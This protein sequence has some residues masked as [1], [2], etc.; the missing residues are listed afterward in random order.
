[1]SEIR[2][3]LISLVV[4]SPQY[5]P[6]A[7][8]RIFFHSSISFASTAFWRILIKAKYL[9]LLALHKQSKMIYLGNM[10]FENNLTLYSLQTFYLQSLKSSVNTVRWIANNL[11]VDILETFYSQSLKSRVSSVV[12]IEKY[13]FAICFELFCAVFYSQTYAVLI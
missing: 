4:T 12:W 7:F 8:T 10:K 6:P 3:D 9:V 1:M 13:N 5:T 2:R 11:T